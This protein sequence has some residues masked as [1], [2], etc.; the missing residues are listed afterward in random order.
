MMGNGEGLFILTE[1]VTPP[2]LPPVPPVD[3]APLTEGAAVAEDVLP[4]DTELELPPDE[5]LVLV[6]EELPPV[7]LAPLELPDT[8]PSETDELLVSLI[9]TDSFVALLLL[10]DNAPLVLLLL[11]STPMM[12]VFSFWLA[13]ALLFTLK[14]DCS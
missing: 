6:A 11:D 1:L 14:S 7:A 8:L 10:L 2:T 9:L 4:P 5:L 13:L 3:D 12:L